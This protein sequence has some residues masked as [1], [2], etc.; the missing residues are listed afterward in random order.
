MLRPT[1]P[2]PPSGTT[3]RPPAA[4]GGGGRELGV[5]VAHGLLRFVRRAPCRRPAHAL[6][7]SNPLSV[8]SARALDLVVGGGDQRQAHG[9]VRPA[10][11]A[12]CRAALAMIAPW[13]RVM[14]AA[15]GR[16]SAAVC[17]ARAVAQVARVD[18][19]RPSA[20]Y[21]GAG[22]VARRR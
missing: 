5:G 4:S 1:S 12:S 11:P 3:R 13:V 16:A 2:R 17:T 10:R 14:I 9:A 20:A 15:D 22:D 19:A 6:G 18:R 7:H 21:C 8:R